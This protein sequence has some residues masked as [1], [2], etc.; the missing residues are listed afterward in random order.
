MN[1]RPRGQKIFSR[2]RRS[3]DERK[4]RRDCPSPEEMLLFYREGLPGKKRKDVST[5]IARCEFCERE[6]KFVI[7]LLKDEKHLMDEIR[8]LIPAPKKRTLNARRIRS[9]RPR[10]FVPRYALGTA[11]LVAL[12]MAL[13]IALLPGRRSS[14]LKKETRRY[15]SLALENIAA[16]TPPLLFAWNGFPD[17]QNLL[18]AGVV[19]VPDMG[20]GGVNVETLSLFAPPKPPTGLNDFYGNYGIMITASSDGSKAYLLPQ[21]FSL[22]KRLPIAGLT[23]YF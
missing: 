12:A 19:S 4:A 20:R 21:S 17:S 3:D 22:K 13:I 7:D 10:P 15:N 18:G 9:L 14:P 1:N 6:S 11:L 23:R 5:H 2:V 16:S 8:T